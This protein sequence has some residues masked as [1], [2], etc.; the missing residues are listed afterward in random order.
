MEQKRKE[1]EIIDFLNLYTND[2]L[3]YDFSGIRAN[4]KYKNIDNGIERYF[5]YMTV[6][7]KNNF[8]ENEKYD[9]FKN[10]HKIVKKIVDDYGDVIDADSKSEFLQDIY[11]Y[12]WNKLAHS[13][14][15][16]ADGSIQGETLNSAATT[17][18]KYYEFLE[19]ELD[20]CLEKTETEHYKREIM[21]TEKGTPQPISKKFILSKYLVEKDSSIIKEL[22]KSESLEDFLKHYHTLGNFMPVPRDCNGPR[23]C[24]E[25]KDYWDL[26]LLHIYNY[27]KM[28]S[29]NAEINVIEEIKKIIGDD[30]NNVAHYKEWLDSFSTWHNFVEENYLE[31]FVDEKEKDYYPL[32]L[33]EGHFSSEVLPQD[34]KQCEE[35]FS[36]AK[37]RISWRSWHIV[38][39]IFKK[40]EETLE[41]DK[42][43]GKDKN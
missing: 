31:A 26:T 3:S 42:Q 24:S 43:Y 22:L 28:K 33:W 1:M 29:S 2:G 38:L 40:R 10:A 37:S 19:S 39:G 35:Y 17:L 15:L 14:I 20:G 21:I 11:E 8:K 34:K 7:L 13:T 32:E 9:L 16:K 6:V 36:N 41:G 12:L 18:N 4:E 25:V 30:A 5:A 27:Y 23:G